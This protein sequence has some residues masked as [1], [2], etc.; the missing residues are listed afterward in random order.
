MVTKF[1]YSVFI[2]LL[3]YRVN[4]GDNV[5]FMTHHNKSYFKFIDEI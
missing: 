2:D 4:F 3:H 5:N 1:V